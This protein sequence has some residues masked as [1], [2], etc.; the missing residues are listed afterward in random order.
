LT[1]ETYSTGEV[2]R[3]IPRDYDGKWTGLEINFDKAGRVWDINRYKKGKYI[4]E[5]R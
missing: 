1:T 3:I 5:V 4:N 2:K